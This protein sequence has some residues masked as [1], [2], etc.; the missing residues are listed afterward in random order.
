[1]IA[2]CPNE[3][4]KG[5]IY[6]RKINGWFAFEVRHQRSIQNSLLKYWMIS[7]E[8]YVF[9]RLEI[10]MDFGRDAYIENS[11]GSFTL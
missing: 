9:A 3:W 8:I 1:M 7:P 10:T 2:W 6:V 11:I 5:G 4:A